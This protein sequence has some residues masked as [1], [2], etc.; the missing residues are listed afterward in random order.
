MQKAR[1]CDVVQ[2]EGHAVQDDV[3]LAT[4]LCRLQEAIAVYKE[5]LTARNAAEMSRRHIVLVE[6]PSRRDEAVLTGKTCSGKRVFFPAS[7][8]PASLRSDSAQVDEVEIQAGDYVAVSIVGSTAA[9]LTA[10][11]DAK[12]SIAEFTSIHGSTL[13]P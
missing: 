4:K 3:D 13:P 9:C 1:I 2:R 12:T 11:A 5:V 7:S 8:V 10:R 6:G